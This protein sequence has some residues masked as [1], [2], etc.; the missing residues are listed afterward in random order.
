LVAGEPEVHLARIALEIARDAHPELDIELYLSK[1]QQLAERVRARC[2]SDSNIRDILGQINWV[3]FVEAGLRANDDDY[4]DPRNSYIN[5]VLDRGVGIPISLSLVYW[6]VAEQLGL[7][8]S[9]ANLPV[10]FML[11]FEEDGLP[12]FIDPFHAGAIYNRENCQQRL[13]DIIQQPVALSDSLGAPCSARMVVARML[14][15]LKAIYGNLQD[16]GSLLPI[17]RRLAAISEEEPKELRDLGLLC[18]QTNRLGEAL[19]PLAKYVG[20][21]AGAEDV[22]EIAALVEAIR[23]QIAG[24]N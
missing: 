2:R 19:D 1:I 4:Y 16:V 24:W 18:A 22:A 5:D 15:N 8:L 13:A 11:R 7:E 3:L 6:A 9:G 23:R 14:R 12:W 20:M 21:A 10:H 17:Q